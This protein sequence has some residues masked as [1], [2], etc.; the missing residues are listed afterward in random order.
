MLDVRFQPLPRHSFVVTGS[1]SETALQQAGY[2]IPTERMAALEMDDALIARTGMDEYLLFISDKNNAPVFD[3]CLS[4]ADFIIS[5]EGN[6]WREFLSYLCALDLRHFQP[7]HWLMTSMARVN[8]WLYRTLDG[9]QLLLGV[10]DGYH[11]Y[12]IEILEELKHQLTASN[13]H[14]GDAT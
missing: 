6:D 14:T 10:N 8:V 11:R 3:G 5:L 13:L 7:G 2:P 1:G 4:R 9:Q 12:F